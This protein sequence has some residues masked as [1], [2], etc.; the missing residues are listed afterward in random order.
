MCTKPASFGCSWGTSTLQISFR[1]HV[2]LWISKQ[3]L[4]CAFKI[5]IRLLDTPHSNQVFS[6]ATEVFHLL[7]FATRKS[8][9][10]FC[11]KQTTNFYSFWPLNLLEPL[12]NAWTTCWEGGPG[13]TNHLSLTLGKVKVTGP[14]AAL[15][16]KSDLWFWVFLTQGGRSAQIHLLPNQLPSHI[17]AP[18][19]CLVHPSQIKPYQIIPPHQIHTIPDSSLPD[20]PLPD[21]SLSRSTLPDQLNPR[22]PRRQELNWSQVSHW[23]GRR[24]LRRGWGTARGRSPKW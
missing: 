5:C 24:R 22:S 10:I 19:P 14:P 23:P 20:S 7:A 4:I 8:K 2:F 11:F 3:L 21:L 6:I 18:T 13:T 12:R 16:P 1:T 15:C 9:G 17:H